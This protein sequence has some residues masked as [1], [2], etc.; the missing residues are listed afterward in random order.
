LPSD[1]S[2]NDAFYVLAHERAHLAHGDHLWKPIAYLILSVFWINP[3]VWVAFVMFCRDIECACDEHVISKLVPKERTNYAATL[4]KVSILHR[5]ILASP[6][7]FGE[8]SVKQRIKNV[9]NYKKTEKK[10]IAA[11]TAVF[12]VLLVFFMTNPKSIKANHLALSKHEKEQLLDNNASYTGTH[13]HDSVD[14][15]MPD[16][17]T[18]DYE[19]HQKYASTINAE[20]FT[21][22]ELLST[23]EVYVS[24]LLHVFEEGNMKTF[25]PQEFASTNGYIV[26]KS[27]INDRISYIEQNDEGV[28]HLSTRVQIGSIDMDQ[29]GNLIAEAEGT[30]RY[31]AYGYNQEIKHNYNVT[32]KNNDGVFR[33]IDIDSTD[34]NILFVKNNISGMNKAEAVAY[35]DSFF[36]R[37]E[38]SDD[39]LFSLRQAVLQ[40]AESI[41]SSV[42]MNNPKIISAD[43]FET[44]NGYLAAKYYQTLREW[45]QEKGYMIKDHSVTGVI[46]EDID[47]LENNSNDQHLL[48]KALI[49][50]AYT[51]PIT[52]TPQH[53]TRKTEL[54]LEKDGETEYFIVG[55]NSIGSYEFET[56]LRESFMTKAEKVLFIDKNIR[57]AVVRDG[58]LPM[59]NK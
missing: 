54:L 47:N 59:D 44:A 2:S 40:Y 35:V 50:C 39:P 26:A 57:E 31:S 9:L 7:S 5:G 34:E 33:C 22:E 23:V 12:F 43:E 1:I 24:E 58:L 20:L 13:I 36:K 42:N 27:L 11:W 17:L 6:L 56:S 21:S 14:Y 45:Y 55:F 51:D 19:N 53:Y 10:H 52:G 4:L 49:N 48:V 30:I 8:I 16:K 38:T 37:D 28:R 18:S 41:T 46:I 29:N 25:S 32:I 15:T 3:L